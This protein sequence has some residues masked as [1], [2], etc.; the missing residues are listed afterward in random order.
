[1][2]RRR[3]CHLPFTLVRSWEWWVRGVGR[4]SKGATYKPVASAHFLFV[5]PAVLEQ[6]DVS[7]VG[8]SSN[9]VL[10]CSSNVGF[11]GFDHVGLG[12]VGVDE[13]YGAISSDEEGLFW[14]ETIARTGWIIARRRHE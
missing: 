8:R 9:D 5:K 3:D 2:Y 7:M 11:V 14:V 10:H 13:C 6:V 1:M 4:S 12:E